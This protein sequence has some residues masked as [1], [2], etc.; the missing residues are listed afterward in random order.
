MFISYIYYHIVQNLDLLNDYR[1]FT[2]ETQFP[3]IILISTPFNN[4]LSINIL[5]FLFYYPFLL[6][7]TVSKSP[8][9]HSL[10]FPSAAI[11]IMPD[12]LLVIVVHGRGCIIK[13]GDQVRPDICDLR[14]CLP[15]AVHDI[16]HMAAV[17]FQETGFYKLIGIILP[18][19]TD[20]TS[21]YAHNITHCFIYFL[22][23][24]SVIVPVVSHVVV[25]LQIFPDQCHVSGCIIYH[26]DPINRIISCLAV[27]A[28]F[29][30]IDLIDIS[31]VST[32]LIVIIS[33][34]IIR[35]KIFYFLKFSFFTFRSKI[36]FLPEVKIFYSN[37]PQ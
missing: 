28:A 1:L 7:T 4:S 30:L 31:P 2:T 36:S 29:P 33:I 19:D 14:C 32:T 23:H 27:P 26:I 13:R 5:I 6:P 37:F 24:L 8:S 11:H 22:K 17:Q 16:S 25:I 15:H 21:F 35:G 3:K 20:H 10:L 34:V 18:I 12:L 9:L